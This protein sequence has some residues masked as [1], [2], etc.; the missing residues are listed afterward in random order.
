MKINDGTNEYLATQGN[1]SVSDDIIYS[2]K[3]L[4]SDSIKISF[5]PNTA[6]N[7]LAGTL[8]FS[9]LS[10]NAYSVVADEQTNEILLKVN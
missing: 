7:N 2:V 3:I 8:S 4:S 9:V 10:T 5:S 6:F 1:F